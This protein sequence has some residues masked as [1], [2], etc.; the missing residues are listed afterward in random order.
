MKLNQIYNQ[1]VMRKTKNYFET[2]FRRLALLTIATKVDEGDSDDK[3]RTMLGLEI[4]GEKST[5]GAPINIQMSCILQFDS[6]QRTFF[7]EE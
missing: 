5:F 4:M 7:S 6:I 1:I 3:V 2:V